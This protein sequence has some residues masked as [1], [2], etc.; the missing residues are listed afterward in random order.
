MAEHFAHFEFLTKL[1]MR[2]FDDA[3]QYIFGGWLGQVVIS[4]LSQ[5]F[6]DILLLGIT[7]QHDYRQLV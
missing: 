4:A 2:V 7:R 5:T 3:L 6:D 1:E